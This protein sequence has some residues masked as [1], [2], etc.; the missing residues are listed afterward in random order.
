[1]RGR[2]RMDPGVCGCRVGQYIWV[3]RTSQDGGGG[4][5]G[6]YPTK[7]RESRCKFCPV[8]LGRRKRKNLGSDPGDA[9]L[10]LSTSNCAKTA[11]NGQFGPRRTKSL[12]RPPG[13]ALRRS[14]K[15]PILRLLQ[16]YTW[17]HYWDTAPMQPLQLCQRPC[18]HGPQRRLYHWEMP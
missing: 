1:M 9:L 7:H 4:G 6:E 16:H 12:W 10:N 2:Q 8:Q 5:S 17:P 18:S 14:E 15:V 11:L 13:T 3:R